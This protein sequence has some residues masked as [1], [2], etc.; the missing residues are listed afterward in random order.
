MHYDIIQKKNIKHLDMYYNSIYD[1]I[2]ITHVGI[3]DH[4]NDQRSIWM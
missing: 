3:T 2:N 4:T 1:I